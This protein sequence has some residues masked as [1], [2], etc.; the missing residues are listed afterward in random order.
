[1]PTTGGVAK[2]TSQKPPNEPPAESVPMS[3]VA[4]PASLG[5]GEVRLY[6]VRK[7]ALPEVVE[8]PGEAALAE[9]PYWLVHFPSRR[10]VP[11]KGDRGE[12]L[13]VMKKLGRGQDV[14]GVLPPKAEKP[15]ARARVCVTSAAAG[16][17]GES[18]ETEPPADLLRWTEVPEGADFDQAM[19]IVFPVKRLMQHYERLLFAAE[20][21]FDRE[22]KEV[23][24]REA[25]P[26]QFQMLSRISEYHQGRPREREKKKVEKPVLGIT[27]LRQKLLISPEYRQAMLE[28][29]RDCE[30]QAAAM[31]GAGTK[32]P[33]KA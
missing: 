27:E 22:G 24:V 7:T 28:M 5:S 32:P 21:V 31:A 20:S 29:I 8:V 16:E 26:T 1:M 23:G 15:R 2:K 17:G 33:L 14:A 11:V 25:F 9:W 4:V 3:T 12:A 18:K 30:A 19:M 6:D 10:C 13:A